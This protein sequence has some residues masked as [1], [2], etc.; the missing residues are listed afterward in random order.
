MQS[1]TVPPSSTMSTD[2]QY[3][4]RVDIRDGATLI[5]PRL[6]QVVS[7]VLIGDRARF[8]APKLDE[9]L[10]RLFLNP[11]SFV[12]APRLVCVF[13]TIDVSVGAMFMENDGRI[14]LPP[15]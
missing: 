15:A 12:I 2:A 1:I 13:E 7:Y 3:I 14:F 9:I 4:Y 11:E 6:V 5:A 8:I 10:N